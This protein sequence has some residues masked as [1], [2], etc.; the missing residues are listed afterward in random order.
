MLECATGCEWIECS[1]YE[2]ESTCTRSETMTMSQHS[3]AVAAREVPTCTTDCNK[4]SAMLVS[5]LRRVGEE[6]ELK[7]RVGGRNAH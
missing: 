5:S 6:V 3:C 7:M 1:C 4:V 2:V